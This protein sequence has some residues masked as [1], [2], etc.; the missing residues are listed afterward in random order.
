M[1]EDGWAAGAGIGDVL[2]GDR[3]RLDLRAGSAF[4]SQPGRSCARSAW[5]SWWQPRSF[6]CCRGKGYYLAGAIVPLVAAG[7][8]ALAARWS[9]RRLVIAGVVLAVSAASLGRRLFRCYRYARMRPP[10]IP[11]STPTSW[12]R[13]VGPIL[14][15]RSAPRW[16]HCRSNSRP[17]RS[18][19]R[20]TMAR[21][22][23]E[24]Y[25]LERP[26]FSGHNAFGDWGRHLRAHA[27]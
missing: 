4:A 12:K 23:P 25:G 10:S 18:F 11:P 2:T 14:S 9:A 22:G 15:A 6:S 20:V 8:T 1:S 5:P 7:C 21:Q 16:S 17:P 13:S 3:H 27:R 24:W 26:V 19:S